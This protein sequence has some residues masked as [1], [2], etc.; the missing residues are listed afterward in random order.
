MPVGKYKNLDL[1]QVPDHYLDWL[2]FEI[3]LKEPL[4]SAVRREMLK[5]ETG[6]FGCR[7]YSPAAPDAGRI[8]Q[9]YRTLAVK[10]H[11]DRGGTKEAMQAVN[12]F[13]EELKQ[14]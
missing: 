11:P 14:I 8:K 2:R 4:K 1:R 13:Y 7:D 12:E 9:I 5:R 10:W 3:E 6:A